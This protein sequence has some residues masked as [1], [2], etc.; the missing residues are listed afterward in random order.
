MI[1]YS[2]TINKTKRIQRIDM[3]NNITSTDTLLMAFTDSL[4][5]VGAEKLI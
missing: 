3:E 5:N 2:S 4:W 1:E